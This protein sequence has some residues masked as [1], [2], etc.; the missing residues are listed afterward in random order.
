MRRSNANAKGG[1]EMND[2][3]SISTAIAALAER[4]KNG[5]GD[6]PKLGMD[7]AEKM[8]L[9]STAAAEDIALLGKTVI[10][11]AAH[12]DMECRDLA[13]MMRDHGQLVAKHIRGF[14]ALAAH[15]GRSNRATRQRITGE[16]PPEAELETQPESHELE[17]EPDQALLERP[18]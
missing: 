8:E 13:S 15:V 17:E 10:E 2:S 14:S 4:A 11:T 18:A 3:Q 6:A 7:A 1:S 5:E 9:L 16:E 12:I